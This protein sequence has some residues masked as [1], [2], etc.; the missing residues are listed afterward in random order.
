MSMKLKSMT[1]PPGDIL[2][3]QGDVVRALF[4]IV[5]GS[6]EIARDGVVVAIIGES[7]I[8]NTVY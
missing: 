4:F 1:A 7:L 6:I 2:L 5:K 3:H 8:T